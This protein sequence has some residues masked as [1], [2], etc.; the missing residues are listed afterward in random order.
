MQAVANKFKIAL[1]ENAK[2][3]AWWNQLP[4]FNHNEFIGWA[5]HPVDKPYGVVDIR[6]DLEHPSSES[7]NYLLGHRSPS[8]TG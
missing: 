8:P 5:S 7:S 4:E 3:V 2:N 1:N 6:S